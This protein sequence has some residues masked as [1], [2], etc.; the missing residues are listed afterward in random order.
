[1]DLLSGLFLIPLL[2]LGN[3]LLV[4]V[5]GP[6]IDLEDLAPVLGAAQQDRG[7]GQ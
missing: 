4:D 1:M 6:V 3:D 2:E 5:V 7:S